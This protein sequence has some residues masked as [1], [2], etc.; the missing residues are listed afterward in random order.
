MRA[1]RQILDELTDPVGCGLSLELRDLNGIHGGVF[2]WRV[3]RRAAS[4]TSGTSFLKLSVG[5]RM[6][7]RVQDLL[8]G[9]CK[10]LTN[11]SSILQV[12]FN[13]LY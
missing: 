3:R 8:R 1:F 7:F 4:T 13:I 12:F 6:H 11:Q 9:N 2:G 10:I 5:V